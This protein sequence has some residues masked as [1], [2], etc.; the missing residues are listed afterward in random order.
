MSKLRILLLAVTAL[1]A[2]TNVAF[3]K[4]LAWLEC[5]YSTSDNSP[6]K[7]VS[8][9]RYGIDTKNKIVKLWGWPEI[10]KIRSTKGDYIVFGRKVRMASGKNG[11]AEITIGR[12]NGS[13][14]SRFKIDEDLKDDYFDENFLKETLIQQGSCKKISQ[15][16]ALF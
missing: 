2:L 16:Q 4:D 15:P 1:I 10:Y 11:D 14:H 8:T 3:S 7:E 6:S 5:S 9:S 13:Y 12:K